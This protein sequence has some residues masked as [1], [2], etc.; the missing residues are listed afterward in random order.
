MITSTSYFVLLLKRVCMRRREGRDGMRSHDDTRI[1][2]QTTS[3]RSNCIVEPR[4]N[5]SHT[6]LEATAT[7]T[8]SED[9]YLSSVSKHVHHDDTIHDPTFLSFDCPFQCDLIKSRRR[10][11]MESCLSLS[12]HVRNRQRSPTQST[13]RWPVQDAATH[14][15][16]ERRV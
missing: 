15:P 8:R 5:R 4:H 12:W 16:H 9:L 10:Q 7:L 11:A 13:G 14:G 1:P 3:M 2:C 6:N